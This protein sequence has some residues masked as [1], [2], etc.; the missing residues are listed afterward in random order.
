MET[1]SFNPGEAEVLKIPKVILNGNRCSLIFTGERLIITEPEKDTV[2]ESIPYSSVAHAVES[3]NSL[4]E[5]IIIVS[6]ASYEPKTDS[7]I[8]VFARQGGQEIRERDRSLEV[9]KDHGVMTSV[10]M[11]DLIQKTAPSPLP[12]FQPDSFKKPAETSIKPAPKKQNPL[13]PFAILVLV[14]MVVIAGL[15]FYDPFGKAKFSQPP[16][17][18]NPVKPLTPALT[19]ETT[20]TPATSFAPVQPSPQGLNPAQGIPSR[21]VWV[22]IDLQGNYSGTV[23]AQGYSIPVNASGLTYYQLPVDEGM[24]EGSIEK[25]D[26]TGNSL[27]VGIYRD[28]QPIY[29]RDTTTPSGVIDF[30]V[31][32]PAPGEVVSATLAT[33]TPEITEIART[34]TLP[35]TAIPPS[36]IW[37]RIYYN[38]DYSGTLGSEGVFQEVNSSGD[39]FFHIPIRNGVV[40]G[41]VSKLDGSADPLIIAVY[42]DGT[43]VSQLFTFAPYGIIDIH[44]PV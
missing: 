14:V 25:Q 5:P 31:T 3:E 2:L 34:A 10:T 35:Q 16:G 38:R 1:L 27:E 41:T 43:Q 37:A 24:I 15:I 11:P 40:E 13:I 36:G 9:L 32:L 12:L 20:F 28:G 22:R 26:A 18:Y 8:L 23:G 33:P 6:L 30:H 42:R 17:T 21:G 4:H 39:Q 29:I 7:R 19:P 44:I